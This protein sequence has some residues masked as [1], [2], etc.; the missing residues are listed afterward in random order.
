MIRTLLVVR[1]IITITNTVTTNILVVAAASV[2][3]KI[4]KIRRRG[5]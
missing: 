3:F 1:G 5:Y 2:N 4:L